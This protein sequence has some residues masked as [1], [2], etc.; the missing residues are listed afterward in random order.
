VSRLFDTLDATWPA[1]R[2]VQRGPFL[3]REG[4]GG[5]SRVSAATLIPGESWGDADIAAA[6]TAMTSLGQVPLFQVRGGEDAL[7]DALAAQ[8]FGVLDPVTAWAAP[9]AALAADLPPL[10]AFAI[11]PPLAIMDDLWDDGGIGPARR[12]VMARAKGPCMAFFART[13]DRPAAVAFAAC[14]GDMAML[15]ALHTRASQRRQGAARALVAA[16]AGWARD[17][18]ARDLAL[19]VTTANAPANA[20]YAA[21][22]MTVAGHYHYRIRPDAPG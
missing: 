6:A 19:M 18:G 8:G 12:A 2:M 17:A 21:L 15:H 20:L 13:G 7:D 3:L 4:Q 22:G 11:W 1:A 10:A 14:H 16:A 5:G 9:C